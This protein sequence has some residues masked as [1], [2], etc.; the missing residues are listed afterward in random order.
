MSIFPH[1]LSPL[2]SARPERLKTSPRCSEK[3][4]ESLEVLSTIGEQNEL[5]AVENKFSYPL[6]VVL[7]LVDQKPTVVFGARDNIHQRYNVTA[8]NGKPLKGHRFSLADAQ[9]S[10]VPRVQGLKCLRQSVQVKLFPINYRSQVC[11]G[12]LQC[13][14]SESRRFAEEIYEIYADYALKNPF[15]S[16]D[17]PI[18]AEKFDEALRNILEKH[19]KSTPVTL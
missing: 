10:P 1:R 17:M 8:V 13:S 6:S 14:H 11:R 3:Y 7:E 16:V 19:D 9:L 12:R 4:L 15:Y 5:A 2:S 18:R